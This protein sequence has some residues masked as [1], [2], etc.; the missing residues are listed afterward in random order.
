MMGTWT[1]ALFGVPVR[2]L[3]VYNLTVSLV[4]GIGLLYL[5]YSGH[6]VV[7]YRRFFEIIAVGLFLS[8]LGGTFLFFLSDALRHT[9]HGLAALVIT[10]G[11]YDLVRG[12]VP[13]QNV[14]WTVV[15]Y[16]DP[17][18][19]GEFGMGGPDEADAEE[20]EG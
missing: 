15:L 7:N 13:G 19:A 3:D 12:E 20:R 1:P 14:D 4:A 11:L 17:R 6:Y 5:L 8:L 16:S 2:L 9:I 18:E 10:V